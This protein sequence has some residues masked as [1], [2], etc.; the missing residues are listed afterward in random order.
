M[1]NTI[2]LSLIF[3][4]FA[5]PCGAQVNFTDSNTS[6]LIDFQNTLSGVNQGAFTG[7]GL[8]P[9]P[10]NGQVDADAWAITGMSDGSHDFGQTH[11][12]GDF[13]RGQDGNGAS[14][15]GLYAFDVGGGNIGMGIQPTGSDWTPG[16]ITLKITNNGSASIN[17]LNINYVVYVRN[18]QS[19]GSSFNFS[20]S[21]NNSTYFDETSLALTSPQ[22]ADASPSWVANN[23]SIGLINLGL[24]PGASYYLRWAGSDVNGSG[25]RDE[26]AL[27]DISIEVV[28]GNNNC[29][30]PGS[31]ASNLAFGTI[32]SNA[33]QGTFTTVGADN[34]LVI[35]STGSSLTA[36]PLDGVVYN[37]GD[38]IGNGTVVQYNSSNQ[39]NEQGL[40]SSTQYFFFIFSADDFCSTAPDY[41]TSLPLT[42]SA[43]TD[44]D[45]S[46]NY[47]DGINNETCSALKTVLHN[48]IKDH[49]TVS[50]SQLWTVYQTTDDHPNDAGT[51]TIV[52]DMYSDVPNGS[53]NE[54]IFVN[55]QCGTYQTEGNCYNREHS[56]PKSWWGGATNVPMY[57]D[58][59]TVV[60]VDGW[61]NG[62]RNNNPYGEV[63][64]GTE[65]QITNNGSRLGSSSI[66]IPGYSAS[67]FEP[68]DEYKGD[69]ARGYFYMA[70]RYEDLVDGWE[71][72]TTES[73]AVLDGTAY[74]AFESWMITMLLDWHT[75][76]PVNQKEIDRNEAIFG[77]QAN[78]NP[79]IDHPEYAGLIWGS[80]GGDTEAPTAPANLTASNTT[81]T[82]TELSWDSS[83]DNVGVSGY[84]IFQDGLMIGFETGTSSNILGLTAATS[85]TFFVTA[86]DAAGN[87]STASNSITVTTNTPGGPMV[88]LEGYFESGW[89]GWQDG[90]S[91]CARYS[92]S[93]SAEG[94]YSIRIR[95]NSGTASAM[96]SPTVNLS[97]FNT[98]EVTFSFYARGMENNE[99]FWLRYFDGNSWITIET[100]TRGI[101]F[102]NNI[103]YI[104]T[105][106]FSSADY[107][108]PS[109]AQ[110]R[111]QC[112]ASVNND[113]IYIDEVIITG[114]TAP[115]A[116]K[117]GPSMVNLNAKNLPALEFEPIE[118]LII[119][120]STIPSSGSKV[121][122]NPA[123]DWLMVKGYHTNEDIS[124]LTIF[125]IAGQRQAISDDG[126]GR[127]DI[128]D[129]EPGVYF[130]RIVE[131]EGKIETLRFI[132][133]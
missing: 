79:F 54:F 82:S 72:F 87:E 44:A 69:F 38:L 22:T 23:R 108:F 86:I 55:D 129:L 32:T 51:Q 9:S 66:N 46:S 77:I 60:P 85:Y 132:V 36:N 97:T 106:S 76:D 12:S 122:P 34:Y 56:F 24:S 28:G 25:S 5:L 7:S 14:T 18:D 62:I 31:Q 81:E 29:T 13:A 68:I 116:R 75:N 16:T 104:A 119:S 67:V 96:T 120:E 57:T 115:L 63:Q 20:H 58:I 1:K 61:I 83:S 98:A 45:G 100:F 40:Q 111:L 35:R 26:F 2:I 91:D 114:D 49:T 131:T 118:E 84:N 128:S 124:A 133:Q 94:S 125:N 121:Y 59:F 19:R 89:D 52:W 47:Y 21:S 10:S 117:T 130:I 80:C 27:D 90:G 101:D 50:Y 53:E 110:F 112:D 123:T 3:F 109:N 39:F 42:G 127:L 92:G 74:P 103:F 33:I 64:A 105:V 78:R 37:S 73:D 17:S 8:S 30:E 113:R 43:S 48:L 70:T 6:V 93:Y 88:L 41:L 71:G 102:S 65:T 99:D 126:N 4:L 95:D 11:T 107:N 15:G